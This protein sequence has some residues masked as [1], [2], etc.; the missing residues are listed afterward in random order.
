MG[1]RIKSD[2]I[3]IIENHG[4]RYR[5]IVDKSLTF[6]LTT[7]EMALAFQNL[8]QLQFLPELKN[9]IDAAHMNRIPII[10]IAYLDMCII[11]KKR[12]DHQKFIFREL[13]IDIE[14]KYTIKKDTSSSLDPV[15]PELLNFILF[16]LI[17]FIL[18]GSRSYQYFI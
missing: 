3:K 6:L 4:G 14:S 12:L 18:E 2:V 11:E 16:L 1:T 15:K 17:L 10:D 8:Y 9:Q 5:E 7:N 13:L